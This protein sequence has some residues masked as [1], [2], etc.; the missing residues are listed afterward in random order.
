M[1][2]EFVNLPALIQ[3]CDDWKK[4]G[5]A[6]QA[7]AAY[8]DWLGS[9]ASEQDAVAAFN[10]GVL[11]REQ[12]DLPGALAAYQKALQL[13]SRLYQARVNL[14]LVL[15]AMGQTGL[16]LAVWRDG[17]LEP[18]G[19]TQLL[20]QMGRLLE[21][22]K[23]LHQAESVLRQSLALDPHQAAVVQHWA[24]LRA[25]QC[26]WPAVQAV[27][28]LDG[29][30]RTA[31]DLMQ[32]VGPFAVMALSDDP[33]LLRSTT[34]RWLKARGWMDQATVALPPALP[35][36]G[37]D[38]ARRLRI[39][40][41]SCDF[42]MHAVGMLAAPLL[43]NHNR[44]TVEVFALDDT[45][46]GHEGTLRQRLLDAVE[47]HVPLQAL[48]EAQAAQTI[49]QLNLDVLVDLTGM[50]AGA[51]MGIVARK[52]ARRVVSY[53]GFMGSMALPAV[54]HVLVD[55]FAFPPA[56]AEH[57]SETP[58]Y[59]P[60]CY[61]VNEQVRQV[62]PLPTRAQLGLPEEAFVF[63]A[64]SNN[65][66]ITPEVFAVWMRVL[67][68]VP[69]SVLWLLEDNASVPVNL[70][71]EAAAAG[72]DPQRLLFAG[73]LA[74]P[75]YL[76]RFACADLM[77]DTSPYGAGLTASDALWMGLPLVTCPGRPLASRMAGSLLTALG[78]PELI[79]D[80]LQAYE[81][82]AVS[83]GQD[84]P[85]AQ[86]LRQRLLEQG[87]PSQVFSPAR[88][89]RQWE[90]VLQGLMAPAADGRP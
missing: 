74:P 65:Y 77:L 62:G 44:E 69:G 61:Q 55:A 17:A 4:T 51:R 32:D 46:S 71:R 40:Y 76:A 37:P 57:F 20:N 81:D 83:L 50:T 33:A 19:Q 67:T 8:R 58:L 2:A 6:D 75:D 89:V 56:L 11:L 54:D 80:S 47:H 48:S 82:L 13:S 63:C 35:W 9:H 53:L 29:E 86:A 66:K 22:Q 3:Q 43:E 1:S 27:M 72:V 14:G 42:R 5:K 21:A 85:R 39:G 38:G 16:A 30:V 52:P 41:L 34:E 31:Q 78:M 23:W 7:V 68:R 64:F 36:P 87:R 90:D 45:P 28:G 88:W 10:L 12:S 49:A 59:H 70:R 79:T 18:Q 26:R 25:R 84:R 24:Y 60:G 15:E 73:R